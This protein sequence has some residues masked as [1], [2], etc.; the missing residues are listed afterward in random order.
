MLAPFI[1]DLR[2]AIQKTT[3]QILNGSVIVYSVTFYGALTY[4][5]IT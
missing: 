5:I 1:Q 4:R 3:I 2:P